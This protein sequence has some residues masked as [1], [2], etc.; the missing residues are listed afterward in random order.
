MASKSSSPKERV[1][2]WVD[3]QRRPFEALLLEA[4]AQLRAKELRQLAFIRSLDTR[5]LPAL[6]RLTAGGRAA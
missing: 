3:A 4:H 1:L 5:N 2:Q 6:S